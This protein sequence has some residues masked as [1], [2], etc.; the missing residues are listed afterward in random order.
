MKNKVGFDVVDYYK[1]NQ[2]Y[3]IENGP[4]LTEP[5]FNS[6]KKDNYNFVDIL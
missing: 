1:P 5:I 2:L 6:S 3:E 4:I